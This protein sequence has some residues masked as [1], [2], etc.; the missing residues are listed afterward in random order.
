MLALA[1]GACGVID[2][3]ILMRRVARPVAS[4]RAGRD[5]QS[6]L[7]AA[8]AGTC[9]VGSQ[10]RPRAPRGDCGVSCPVTHVCGVIALLIT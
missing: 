10:R 3:V 4:L 8:R 5:A 2:D 1:Y 9:V 7:V 6:V